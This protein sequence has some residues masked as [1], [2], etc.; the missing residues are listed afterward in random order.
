MPRGVLQRHLLTDQG[1]FVWVSGFVGGCMFVRD[2]ACVRACACEWEEKQRAR[3]VRHAISY[4]LQQGFRFTADGICT[5]HHVRT[6][7]RVCVCVCER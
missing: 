4:A 1:M 2:R 6:C 3:T 7:V 5:K